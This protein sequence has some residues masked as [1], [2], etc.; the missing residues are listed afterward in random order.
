[1]TLIRLWPEIRQ[2]LYNAKIIILLIERKIVAG[3]QLVTGLPTI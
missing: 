3:M 2:L 1:M